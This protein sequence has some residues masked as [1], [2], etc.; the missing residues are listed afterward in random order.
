[1]EQKAESIKIPMRSRLQM[2]F[3]ASYLVLITFVLIFLNT[4]PLTVSQTMVF[5]EKQ[6][7]LQSQV[8]V[9]A[10]A[11]SALE[12]LNAEGVA[13]VMEML[14]D[15]ALTRVLITDETGLIVYDT[16]NTTLSEQQYA[17]VQEI[18]RA[19]NGYDVFSSSYKDGAFRSSAASPVMYRNGTI[20]SV[21]VY[22]YDSEQ[23][24]LV[25]GLQQNFFRISLVLLAVTILLSLILSRTLTRRI[26]RLISGIEQLRQGTY[27]ARVKVSG[28]DELATLA[29]AF[30]DMTQ[31]LE[32]TDEVRRRF[33]S[34]ASHELK[35]P[36]ASI[37]L[38]T[39][40]IV[41]NDNMDMD[42][43]RE[44]VQDI[45]AEADRLTRITEKLLALTRMDQ[46]HFTQRVVVDL[47]D[48]IS[49]TL[50]MLMPLADEQHI[51]MHLHL[52]EKCAVLSTP[53]EMYQVL[54]NLIENAIKYNVPNG[55]IWLNTIKKE[56]FVVLSVADSGFGILE[57][58]SVCIFDRFY[59]VDKTR[60]RA[61]GGTGL[62]LSIVR[63]TVVANGGTISVRSRDVCGTEFCVRFS[64]L[65]QP[66][67]RGG[68]QS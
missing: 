18:V 61:A 32:A 37:K 63:D 20:G 65:P 13:Q 4:Y 60:S 21:Y 30:N 28:K 12:E 3:A 49:D 48:V 39:D 64:L 44:F 45:G 24:A 15:G 9:M 16:E 55:E 22:D 67:E 56:V 11:L 52:E 27:S 41:Q 10:T 54:F 59:R 40:S 36:L 51:L 42:T 8:S 43:M 68:E 1:M 14:D 66:D 38:L 17:L 29:M 62:G 19:L 34:D 25:V 46:S 31:R 50:H 2:K 6:T 7:S 5:K 57:V 47:S 53:D 35:T 58:D 23:G 33:V 26:S